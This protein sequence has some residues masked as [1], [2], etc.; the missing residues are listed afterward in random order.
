[1]RKRDN[2]TSA[3]LEVGGAEKRQFYQCKLGGWESGKEA[4]LTV[5]SWRC[6][7]RKRD[8][9]NSAFVEV[10]GAEKRQ[11]Y[12]CELG[13]WG[14]VKVTSNCLNFPNLVEFGWM[15]LDGTGPKLGLERT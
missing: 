9:F 14:S 11:F 5:H 6:G 4:I 13:G 10:G 8:N 15:E 12:Q 2:F 3:S 1:V 7:E